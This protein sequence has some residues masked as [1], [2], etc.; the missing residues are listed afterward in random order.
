MDLHT[1]STERQEPS[2]Q[3]YPDGEA[4]AGI[5]E[6]TLFYRA[7]EAYRFFY[8][9]VST[10]AIFNGNR[11]LGVEDGRGVVLMSAG[12]QHLIFT[13][14]SDTPYASATLD[15]R[16]MGP[17]VVELPAGP[18]VGL[19]D[20]HNQRWIADLGLPGADAGKGGRHLFL[21]P[22]YTRVI[23][24]GY[25]AHR[26][27]TYKV[28]LAV[29]AIPLGGDVA[30]A[31]DALRRVKVFPLT[32]PSAVLPFVDATYR[33]VDSTPIRW[34]DNLEYWV[35]LHR[36][37]EGEP[38]LDEFR[39]MYGLLAALGIQAG[40][41]FNPNGILR[42]I[43]PAASLVA[44]EQMRV[45]AFANRRPDL[46]WGDRH[47]EWISPAA[48]DG[49][50]ETH[51]YLDLQAR[52]RW[53]FQAVGASPAMFRRQAGPGSIY[54]LAA[55]DAA[56]AY[57]DGGG[58]YVLEVPQPVPARMFWSVTAYDS[59]SRSQISSPQGKAV[60]GS[61]FV[62]FDREDDGSIALRFGPRPPAGREK[63]WIRT[64]PGAAF[65]LYFRMYGPEAA[66]LNG[67]WRA[68]DVTQVDG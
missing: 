38:P 62:D 18:Y 15:L 56:G 47:W 50:F 53:F 9:T 57:L 11:E 5:A 26:S 36:A 17:V 33:P 4:A 61:L 19:A 27:P 13:A 45:A 1:P 23:P 51:A 16:S 7:V 60:L 3:P 64:V 12:P 48:G 59:R 67:K 65:F 2:Q 6:E 35:H 8:P 44:L 66:A 49:N 34:E 55:R 28:L 22:G 20:D 63:Q 25:H 68:G 41:P 37:L 21:P 31:I 40:K 42:R 58:S 32:H 46:V 43:L 14:N 29:R 39:P 54:F 24:A 30:G 52:D 10:E